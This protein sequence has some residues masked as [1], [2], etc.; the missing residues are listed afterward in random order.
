MDDLK[1]YQSILAEKAKLVEPFF[2]KYPEECAE[3]EKNF[4]D[5]NGAKSARSS[6]K[7]WS[8]EF[9]TRASRAF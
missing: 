3:L 7:L 8:T 5:I 1:N 6:R 9:T 4:A 2:G